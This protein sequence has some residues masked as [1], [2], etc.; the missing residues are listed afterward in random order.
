MAA[1]DGAHAHV[2]FP[3]RLQELR[4]ALEKVSA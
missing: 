1:F 2:R 4:D 3:L